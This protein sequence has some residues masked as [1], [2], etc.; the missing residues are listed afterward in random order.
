MGDEIIMKKLLVVLF[1]ASSGFALQANA[2][3]NISGQA[4]PQQQQQQQ[5][6]TRAG[7]SN[8]WELILSQIELR[9]DL[10]LDQRQDI[11]AKLEKARMVYQEQKRGL[12]KD[13]VDKWKRL[14]EL[15]TILQS[16]GD[17]GVYT[18][19]EATEVKT[20]NQALTPTMQIL[21]AA[22]ITFYNSVLAVLPHDMLLVIIQ[23]HL[24]L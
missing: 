21:A 4:T 6:P 16:R 10:P 23:K 7:V 1:M 2:Q 11:C 17:F 13:N 15:K 3:N 22:Q 18:D 5:K 9:Q 20:L 14:T 24:S 12:A 19:S 8:A